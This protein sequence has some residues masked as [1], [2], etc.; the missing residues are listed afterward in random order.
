[1]AVDP[2][3]GAVSLR[4]V[5]PNPNRRI[6]PGMFVKL[7]AT[8]GQLDHAYKLPQ[9]AIARDAIGGYVLTVDE[10]GMVEQRRVNLEGMTV[11]DWIVTGELKDGDQVIVAG[12]QK[13]RPGAPAKAVPVE[14][15][16]SAEAGS[17][18]TAP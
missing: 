14:D 4:A 12:L 5:I 2:S 13:V 10:K 11:S 16:Q 6:L 7:T 18:P 15:Q 9:A 17:S 3:T 8:I 1:M